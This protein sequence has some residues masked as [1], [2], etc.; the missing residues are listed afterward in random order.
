MQNTIRSNYGAGEETSAGTETITL[1][2]N[3]TS[4]YGRWKPTIYWYTPILMV[5]ETV[6]LV[7][8]LTAF[9]RRLARRFEKESWSKKVRQQSYAEKPFKSGGASAEEEES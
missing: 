6:V 7:G 2:E 9:I 1:P 5:L 8:G 4:S 3:P